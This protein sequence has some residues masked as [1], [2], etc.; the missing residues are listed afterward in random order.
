MYCIIFIQHRQGQ[1]ILKF[2]D[3]ECNFRSNGMDELHNMM[4]YCEIVTFSNNISL[5]HFGKNN[6][7]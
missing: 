3:Y 6:I 7:M 4:K 1:N 5:T 2:T